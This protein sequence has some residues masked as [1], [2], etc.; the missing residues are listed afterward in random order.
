MYNT[1]GTMYNQIMYKT[2]RNA[3]TTFMK[4]ERGFTLLELLIASAITAIV[5]IV[6]LANYQSFGEDQNL[7]S[8]VLDLQTQIR[9][10][11]TSATTNVLCKTATYGPDSANWWVGNFNAGGNKQRLS[12]YC[13]ISV[14]ANQEQGSWKDYYL[15]PNITIDRIC[16]DNKDCIP[17]QAICIST[18]SPNEPGSYVSVIFKP[19]SG[20]VYFT[21]AGNY[22]CFN[23]V[24]S[25]SIVLKN[26]QTL[27]TKKLIIDK[28]KIYGQ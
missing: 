12:T 19:L 15:P 2:A 3:F 23:A 25:M 5:G 4:T 1:L 18:L 26:T 20:E 27:N 14:G 10:V 7:K 11:Q 22:A 24:T 28:G 16:G 13:A 21:G 8:A 6:V 9:Q 17:Q